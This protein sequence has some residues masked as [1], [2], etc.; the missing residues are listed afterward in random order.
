MVMAHGRACFPER[1]VGR[2]VTV[3]NFANFT[4]VAVMQMVAGLIVGAFPA[5]DGVAPEAA[6]RSA[7]AFL[8]A[9]LAFALTIYLRVADAKPSQ[10]LGA[11]GE[12]AA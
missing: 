12:P 2:A 4:G 1:L 3:V 8:A 11:G 7:F 10:D 9:T 6:Y 5:E